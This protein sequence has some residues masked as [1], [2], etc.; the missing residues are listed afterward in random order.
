[1]FACNP[2]NKSACRE[3]KEASATPNDFMAN[4]KIAVIVLFDEVEMFNIARRQFLQRLFALPLL[5]SVIVPLTVNSP[6][7]KSYDRL[8]LVNGW[9][10][11]ES[12][13]H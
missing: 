9:V 10:V 4:G 1:M 13:L 5:G 11:L 7:D 6:D 2:L 8:L 3:C 12:D